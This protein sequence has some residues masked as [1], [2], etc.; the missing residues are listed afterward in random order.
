[1]CDKTKHDLL[2]K[3]YKKLGGQK[4]KIR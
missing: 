4:W 1:L 3:I 2:I